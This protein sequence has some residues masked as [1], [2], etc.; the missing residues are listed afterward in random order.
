[1]VAAAGPWRTEGDWWLAG[2]W[3]RDEWDV[4]LNDG[5]VYRLCRDASGA[6]WYLDGSYD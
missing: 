4:A 5:G 3:A 6:R 1:V 2:A